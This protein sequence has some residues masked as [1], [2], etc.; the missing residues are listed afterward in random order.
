MPIDWT[1]IAQ[2]GTSPFAAIGVIFQYG[3]LVVFFPLLCWM[4]WVAWVNWLQNKYDMK[5]KHVLLAIDVPKAN[6]ASMRAVEHIIGAMH[7]VHFSPTFFEKYWLGVI[8]D[9]FSLEIVSIDGYIQYFIRC[10]DYNVDLVKGAVYA[11]Y[12]DAEIIEVEDYVEQVPQEFPDEEYDV[13][14]T[15]FVLANKEVYPIKT[16]ESFEHSLTGVFADPMATILELMSRLR[17][18]EQVWLQIVIT[19]EGHEWREQSLKEVDSLIGKKNWEGDKLSRYPLK[20]L[21]AVHE[22][23]FTPPGGEWTKT[24]YREGE[25][26]AG[27][28]MGMTTGDRIIVEEV[29]KKATRLPFQM[30]F[31]FIY[32]AP[33]DVMN[34]YRVVGSIFGAVKQFNALDLNSFVVGGKT[35]TSSPEL[36][37]VKRRQNNRKRKIMLGYKYRS[38]WSGEASYVMSDVE[39]ATLFHFP[40]IEVKAPLVSKSVSKKAEPPTAL[41]IEASP[42]ERL[43]R[44]HRR[45]VAAG[46]VPAEA[47]PEQVAPPEVDEPGE[48]PPPPPPPPPPPGGQKERTQLHSMEGLPPGVKPVAQE[49][50][51][52]DDPVRGKPVPAEEFR[53]VPPKQSPAQAPS[54]PAQPAAEPQPQRDRQQPSGPVQPAGGPPSN[55]PI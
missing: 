51:V 25:D 46:E 2:L 54:Q 4:L 41:P 45:V 19:P 52:P 6:E 33:K 36:F 21:E 47:E 29:Q 8:Q 50:P 35:C 10:D 32:A 28:F 1:G 15:E 11:Q 14:G 26:E 9:K 3:G 17:P 7:G 16:Y 39:I 44:G 37:M 18:G 43:R 55:L 5:K 34:S 24:E 48:I 49:T 13:W 31:R 12:P 40:S 27:N 42:F 53:R 30:K 22:A 20:A 38:N 23:V